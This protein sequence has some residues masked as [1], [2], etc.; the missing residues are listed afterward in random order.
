MS[1]SRATLSISPSHYL[2]QWACVARKVS[3]HDYSNYLATQYYPDKYSNEMEILDK[4]LT[5][6]KT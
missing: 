6:L 4:H 2:C 5:T 3:W 1:G